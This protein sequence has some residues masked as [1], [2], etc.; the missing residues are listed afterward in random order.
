M[1]E[2]VKAKTYHARLGELKNAFT[3][4]VDYILTDFDTF[5]PAL[6]SRNRWNLWS[7]FD[8]HHGGIR[9]QGVGVDWFKTQL[10][11]RGFD[12]K[13]A[14][15]LLLTQPSFLGYNFNP[16]S[17]WIAMV[18]GRARAFIAEVN[19]TFGDRH[20]YFCA[21]EDFSEIRFADTLTAQKMMH[22][23][24]FQKVEGT[25]RFNFEITEAAINIRIDY[26]NKD[27][28]VLATLTG[29]RRAATDMSLFLA[30][31][32]RPFGAARVLALIHWQAIIL[33]LKKAPFLKKPVAPNKLITDSDNF[34]R[35]SND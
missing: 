30:A 22:V 16:V 26:R 14:Q 29:K 21:Q 7:F 6:I 35:A 15:L 23:S 18:D 10:S 5:S 20:C 34:H 28:G 32:R 27:Q 8:R 17:F 1:L 11:D 12:P 24:P 25:Y 33:Y 3:Y 19:N 2:H 4:G 31:L 9:G 13:K